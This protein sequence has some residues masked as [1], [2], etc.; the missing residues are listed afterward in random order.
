MSNLEFAFIPRKISKKIHPARHAPSQSSVPSASSTSNAP[1][2]EGKGKD[3]EKPHLITVA[4]VR[5]PVDSDQ[6]YAILV[7]MARSDHALW[8]N[9][10]ICRKTD[11][12][13]ESSQDGNQGCMYV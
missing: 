8:V 3:P 10:E 6:D 9:P 7:S 4:S 5:E 1:V 2:S 13:A 11:D 12:Q